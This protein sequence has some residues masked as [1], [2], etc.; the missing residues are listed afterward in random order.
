MP[1]SGSKNQILERL[2]P[3]EELILSEISSFQTNPTFLSNSPKINL[4]SA[5]N[6]RN[7]LKISNSSTIDISI[8]DAVASNNQN[9]VDT[10]TDMQMNN[11]IPIRDVI[12]D[13]LLQNQCT[14]KKFSPL[15]MKKSAV[16]FSTIIND[17]ESSEEQQNFNSQQI[18]HVRNF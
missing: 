3:F 2:K 12:N 16:N 4:N 10:I 1:V 6:S 17:S 7:G 14:E 8:I 15:I 9:V 11:T 13:Y 5:K 18:S